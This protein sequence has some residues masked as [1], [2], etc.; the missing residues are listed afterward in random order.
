MYITNTTT[1]NQRFDNAFRNIRDTAY[2]AACIRMLCTRPLDELLPSDGVGFSVC[3]EILDEKVSRSLVDSHDSASPTATNTL[4]YLANMSCSL[5][6]HAQQSD[7]PALKKRC[8]E[9]SDRL[10]RAIVTPLA[11]TFVNKGEVLEGSLRSDGTRPKEK[12]GPRRVRPVDYQRI[13]Q[14]NHLPQ[15]NERIMRCLVE[16]TSFMTMEQ[17][18]DA[19]MLLAKD[20]TE[21]RTVLEIWS[22][23]SVRPHEHWMKNR[24]VDVYHKIYSASG[25]SLPMLGRLI[26]AGLLFPLDTLY[27]TGA[28]STD[29]TRPSHGNEPSTEL[30]RRLA[31]A[32]AL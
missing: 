28:L 19:C 6:R 4:G 10:A 2:H 24:L 14:I 12:P 5:A 16:T 13:A 18:V 7:S 11:A 3:Q 1:L 22:A 17:Y 25:D 31:Q 30:S 23:K 21:A 26:R 29:E 8:R 15:N 27:G 20:H 9:Q 32:G